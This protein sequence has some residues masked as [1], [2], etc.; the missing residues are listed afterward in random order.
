MKKS[1]KF[2]AIILSILFISIYFSTPCLIDLVGGNSHNNP[3]DMMEKMSPE[4]KEAIQNAFHGINTDCLRDI[5]VH[6][7]GS[8]SNKSGIWLNPETQD[9]LN[10]KR[11]LKFKIYMSA[12][13]VKT[14]ENAEQEF[15]DRI[16]DLYKNPFPMGK[17][18]ILAFDKNY[19][20][21]GTLNL[22]HTTLFIP[23]DYVYQLSKKHPG[24]F[25]PTISIHPDRKDALREL[26]KWGEKG[27]KFIKWLPNAMRIDPSN[28]KYVPFYNLLKKYNITLLTHTGEE[29]AVEGDH[30]QKLGNPLRLKLPL[31]MGVKVV[32]AHLASLGSCADYEND[33]QLVSCFDLFW[34][35]F[36]DSKYKNNLFGEISAVTLHTR[37]GKPIDTLLQH[38]ELHHR[39]VNGSDYP[40]PAINIIFRT[41]Q[42]LELGYITAEEQ[43]ILNE[44]YSYNPLL[45]DFV[46]K[47]LLKH[48]KTKQKLLP[49]AFELP[50]ELGCHN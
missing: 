7:G 16:L 47:R 3:L 27:V 14:V 43:E 28:S 44:I 20:S 45:F 32:M 17:S 33:N 13:K 23:N 34:R 2:T 31:N 26:T 30:Y 18:H 10:L 40:L 36:T 25:I 1:L 39:I 21:D 41:K 35:L 29:K 38:P 50:K 9:K 11:F 19:N 22:N 15:L 37:I 24:L 48:P 46:S 42:M 12:S 8:G 49:E 6:I 5:H 4:A